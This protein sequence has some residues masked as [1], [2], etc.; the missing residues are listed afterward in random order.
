VLPG[1]IGPVGAIAVFAV[2]VAL[3]FLGL[4]RPLPAGS[5]LV[6]LGTTQ[7]SAAIS[8]TV[9]PGDRA[10]V[11]ATLSGSSG[12]VAVPVLVVGMPFLVTAG[13]ESWVGHRSHH[14]R[15]AL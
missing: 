7:L 4:N 11:N 8:R 6:L 1:D 5:L 14:V 2:A 12:A 9:G 10:P 13:W 15:S 3:A